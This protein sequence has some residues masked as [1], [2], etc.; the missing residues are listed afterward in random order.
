I[1]RGDGKSLTIAAASIMAKVTRDK[2][3]E[4]YH[5][6]YPQ[7]NFNQHKGYATGEHR[8][9]LKKISFCPIHRKSF[10]R[11]LERI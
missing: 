8:R 5:K 2:I 4:K 7:Y 11:C 6:I 10:L 3:M 9:I 1:V